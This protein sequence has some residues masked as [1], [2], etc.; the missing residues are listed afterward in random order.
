VKLSNVDEKFIRKYAQFY[1]GVAT[2]YLTR[3]TYAFDSMPFQLFTS[4][5]HLTLNGGNVYSAVDFNLEN[6]RTLIIE[7]CNFTRISSWNPSNKL[8]SVAI[9]GCQWLRDLPPLDNIKTVN[10]GSCFCL[11]KFQTIGGHA[12]FSYLGF[13]DDYLSAES[14][15]CMVQPS[16]YEALENLN[17]GCH[18]P[19]QFLGFS[20]WMNIAIV[21]LTAPPGDHH[22]FPVFYGVDLRLKNFNLS[23]WN[24]CKELPNLER[25]ILTDC[26]GFHV[27]P[28]SPVLTALCVEDCSDLKTITSL[29]SI[30]I[31]NAHSCLL[32]EKIDYCPNITNAR[33]N[34]CYSLRDF[35]LCS[36]LK[37]LSIRDCELLKTLHVS[38]VAEI[39]GE[40]GL[41]SNS[42]LQTKCR[43]LLGP[44]L[45]SMKKFTFCENIYQVE[46]TAMDALVNLKGFNNISSLKFFSCPNLI[47]TKGI[48][49]IL[50]RLTFKDCT[51]LIRLVGLQ[52]I[53]E[54]FVQDCDSI[55][56]FTGLGNHDLLAF[57]P[58][59]EFSKL[60]KEHEKNKLQH[61][62]IFSTTKKIGVVIR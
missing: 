31:L 38:P 44:N 1:D 58:N 59:K 26:E 40:T 23:A 50:K 8:Q 7:N 60:L 62:K 4:I 28:L 32:L 48:G 24:D 20:L 36:S 41:S 27:F 17:M 35:S 11:M 9:T 25:C 47:T 49:T 55:V 14:Y 6:L 54:V 61:S 43:L 34:D 37:V 45:P 30:Q 33:I 19:A 18:F 16:F 12:K 39:H 13:A 2:L 15:Q 46:L 29:P 42:N 52:G 5:T 56:D 57:S 10:I 3:F 53:P 22:S 51:E 21:A